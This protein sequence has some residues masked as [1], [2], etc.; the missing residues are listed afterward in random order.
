MTNPTAN[1]GLNQTINQDKQKNP[2]SS[3]EKTVTKN[4]VVILATVISLMLLYFLSRYNYLLFHSTVEIFSIVIAF[5]I[6]AIAWN[7]RRI[8]DNNYLSFIG[9]AFLFIAGMDFLHTLAYNG[10]GVF[11]TFIGSNL[12]TQL[13][14]ATRYLL[15]F[16]L[17]IPLLFVHRKI[18]SSIIFVGYSLVFAIFVIS[19]FYLKIFPQA[20]V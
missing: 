1:H 20:Y 11:P 19:I 15:S 8:M 17:L 14:I 5:T 12:A 6:F 16:S 3:R 7:S 2:S 9:I 4:I 18:H 13:W 10:M